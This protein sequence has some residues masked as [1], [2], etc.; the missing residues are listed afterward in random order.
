MTDTERGALHEDSPSENLPIEEINRRIEHD[1]HSWWTR[2][3]IVQSRE[4]VIVVLLGFV[5]GFMTAGLAYSIGAWM[6]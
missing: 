5:A 6:K 4:L 1:R 2:W 3:T